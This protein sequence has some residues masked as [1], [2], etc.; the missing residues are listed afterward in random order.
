MASSASDADRIVCPRCRANNFARATHCFQCRAPFASTPGS[1]PAS[2]SRPQTNTSVYRG[3]SASGTSAPSRSSAGAGRV[4]SGDFKGSGHHPGASAQA[5]FTGPPSQSPA[6]QPVAEWSAHPGLGAPHGDAFVAKWGMSRALAT[7]L[8][9]AFLLAFATVLFIAGRGN[10]RETAPTQVAAPAPTEAP[11]VRDSAP[12]AK[13]ATADDDPIV[14]ESKRYIDRAS[15]HAGLE[16]P[17]TSSDGRVHLRSGG[18]ISPEQYRDA[19][20][21]VDGSPVMHTPIPPPPMP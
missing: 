5:G 17:P 6:P 14:A 8:A 11:A 10:G 12:A 16:Q 4:V 3:G 20:R 18:S 9:I 19:Q 2:S 13:P 1:T 7:V 15:R 21:H